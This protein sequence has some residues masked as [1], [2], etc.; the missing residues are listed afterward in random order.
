MFSLLY[1]IAAL[2]ILLYPTSNCVHVQAT[3][4]RYKLTEPKL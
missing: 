2:W 4:P 3:N 1:D